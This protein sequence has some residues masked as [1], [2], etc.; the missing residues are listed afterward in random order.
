MD[1]S[2]NIGLKMPVS[3]FQ[4]AKNFYTAIWNHEIKKEID[5]KLIGFF[6]TIQIK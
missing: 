6:H 4:R 5:G 3:N 2:K 1:R